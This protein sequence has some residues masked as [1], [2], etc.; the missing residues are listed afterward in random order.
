MVTPLF[1][2]TK[3]RDEVR[4]V[5]FP[6]YWD[7]KEYLANDTIVKKTLFPIYWVRQSR[8]YDKQVIFPFVFS[9]KDKYRQSFTFFPLFSFGHRTD[10]SMRHLAITPFFWNVKRN[11]G[12]STVLFP[13]YWST[14]HYKK[15][16]TIHRE[17]L[18]PFYWTSRSKDHDNKVFF[19]FVWS[20]ENKEYKSLTVFPL[21][22][23][24]QR[25][26]STFAHLAVTPFFWRISNKFG[27][28]NVLF[29]LY[30]NSKH[31]YSS[32]TVRREA[33]FPFYWTLKRKNEENKIF[34]PL[35]YSFKDSSRSRLTIFPLIW[36]Y[37]DKERKS[38]TFF[39]L[40]SKSS[41][42]DGKESTLMVTPLYWKVKRDW[43]TWEV[44][45]PLYWSKQER[46]SDT[47]TWKLLIPLYFSYKDKTVHNQIITPL[48]YNLNGMF[49]KSFTFFP[50]FS[51]GK[52]KDSTFEHLAITPLYWQIRNGNKRTRM[53]FPLYWRH[54]EF[55]KNDTIRREGIFPIV[56]TKRSKDEHNTVLFPL[57]F[58]YKNPKRELFTVFP[59]FSHG[60]NKH[61]EYYAVTPFYWH[62]KTPTTTKNVLFPLFWNTVTKHNQDTSK[63]TVLFPIY[64]HSSN[65]WEHKSSTVLFPLVFN[66]KNK[67][68]HSFT[69]FPL[70][71]YGAR[72][73]SS[74][75]HLVVTPL[76]WRVKNKDNVNTVL[77]PIA[78]GHKNKFKHSFTFFPLFSY[79]GTNDGRRSHLVVTP[80]F[81]R[82]KNE[83]GIR[84]TLFPL[85]WSKK[86]Y[87]L[88]DTVTTRVFFPLYWAKKSSE[89]NNHIFFPLVY[90]LKNKERR[91]FTFFPLFSY[92]KRADSTGHLMVTPLFWKV[93][94]KTQA[95]TTLFPLYVSRKEFLRDDTITKRFFFPL[96]YSVHNKYRKKDIL[97]PLIYRVRD[98]A[99]KS[100][101]F[102]PLFSFGKGVNSD[103]QHLM[104]TPLFGRFHS[105]QET[106]AF[107]FPVFNYRRT[108]DEKHFSALLFLL[109]NT[110]R[111]DYSKTSFLWPICE[112]L[113]DGNTRKFR[114]APIVWYAKTDTSKMFSIQPLF[115]SFKSKE[116]KTFILSAYLY[117]RDRIEGVST[118]NSFL[119][120]AFYTKRYENGDF[121]HRFLHL[122]VANVKVDGHREKSVLP[123]YHKTDEKNGDKS[124]SVFFGF[125]N[126]FKQFKTEINDFY[127][128]ERIF[129]FVRLRSNYKQLKS[130]GKGNFTRRKK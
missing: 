113:K 127:E 36:T 76:F 3:T 77:F 120:R 21:F 20:L 10:S 86:D 115:Y 5:L 44:L 1:W 27:S 33:L 74:R 102:F 46:L 91:S 79:G 108:G 122:I 4:H 49:Y 12:R 50:F 109:R 72:K 118:S 53:F 22:S 97:F 116:R 130:E 40:Y 56:W 92:G 24:G 13:I 34:F 52:S 60:K 51:K 66:F 107:L 58:S 16:D 78:F 42:T 37:N 18:F 47:S 30:M 101:T 129:W 128:E 17:V 119:W 71:S 48:V 63:R 110:S 75:S 123:F 59:L 45:F 8:G 35:I 90:S 100:F 84:T 39:P 103:K 62:V 98:T 55:L 125:Y 111:P 65:T 87:R 28:T 19:P 126:H 105:K 85:Y 67:E 121:E 26:D 80:L 9:H 89:E 99:Y 69:F 96:F 29:P 54:D 7:S 61:R 38:F 11:D 106:N 93:K 73:D 117:K 25:K 83:N 68:R 23:K 15:H 94:N 104:I 81:W 32:D 112:R 14:T 70:F 114:F 43:E 31:I 82:N 64:W 88:Y 95:A 41:T 124:V 6:I 2:R 57:V